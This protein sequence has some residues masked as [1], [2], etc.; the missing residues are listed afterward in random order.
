VLGVNPSISND[1]L[2]SHYRSLI[3][4]NS[5]D[6]LLAR[7]VPKEFITIANKRVAAFDEA[8]DMIVKERSD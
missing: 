4:G 2:K 3:A 5:P 1:A 8:Y 7:G 6:K